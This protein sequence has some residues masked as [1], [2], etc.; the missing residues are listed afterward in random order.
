[1]N[2]ILKAAKIIDPDSPYNNQI[3]DIQIQNNKI[4][5]IDK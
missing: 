2:I 1:M 4:I 5:K 3:V